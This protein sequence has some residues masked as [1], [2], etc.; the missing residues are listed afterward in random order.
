MSSVLTSLAAFQVWI[1]SQSICRVSTHVFRSRMLTFLD[2]RLFRCPFES[3]EVRDRRGLGPAGFVS[4]STCSQL[5]EADTGFGYHH[6][7]EDVCATDTVAGQC[8]RNA[9][10][11]SEA[12]AI[13]LSFGARLC[14]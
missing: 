9:L 6:G 12:E 2:E 10:N 3:T 7:H 11:H 8:F 1:E 5:I 13:C 4:S 14:R